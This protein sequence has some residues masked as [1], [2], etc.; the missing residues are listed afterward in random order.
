VSGV[1]AHIY[2]PSTWGAEAEGSQVSGQ[3]RL[4]RDT[5]SQKTKKSSRPIEWLKH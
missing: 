5:L 4:Q 2:N 1:E 3:P